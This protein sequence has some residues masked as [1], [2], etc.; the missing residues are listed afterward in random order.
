MMFLVVLTVVAIVVIVGAFQNG[1]A[2]TVSFLF[3]QVHAPLAL[4]ILAAAAGGVAIGVLVGWARALQRWR[5]RPATAAPGSAASALD[6]LP[7]SNA[8]MTTRERR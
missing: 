1:Q 5:H 3:W 7:A 6:G 8:S 2:V 4:V